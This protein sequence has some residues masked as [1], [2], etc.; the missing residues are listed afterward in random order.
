MNPL[1]IIEKLIKT[2]DE[3]QEIS[4]NLH[5]KERELDQLAGELLEFLKHK[6]IIETRTVG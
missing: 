1:K 3:L 5:H 2:R 6:R 4:R